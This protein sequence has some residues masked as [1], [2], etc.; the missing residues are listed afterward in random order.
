MGYR[1][2][3]AGNSGN[4]QEHT[5]IARQQRGFQNLK[6]KLKEIYVPTYAL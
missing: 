5:D 1:I 3:T 4:L 6:I 2:T